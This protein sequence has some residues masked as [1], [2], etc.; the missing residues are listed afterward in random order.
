MN[1]NFQLYSELLISI[2][3]ADFR[4]FSSPNIS[5]ERILFLNSLPEKRIGTG[6]PTDL[7]IRGLYAICKYMAYGEIF[8]FSQEV[9][10]H[11][12]PNTDRPH[13]ATD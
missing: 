4:K 1:N 8:T 2:P 9:G 3:H 10:S 12:Y 5:G 11:N 6:G 7:H 13:N